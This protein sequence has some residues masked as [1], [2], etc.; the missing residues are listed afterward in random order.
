[1]SRRTVRLAGG[2]ALAL[3]VA[4][5]APQ[6]QAVVIGASPNATLSA[7]PVVVSFGAAASYAFTAATTPSGPGAAVATSGTAQVT[8]LGGVTDF[9]PGSSIDQTGEI[10]TFAAFPAASSIPYSAADD[11]IGLA[12]TLP[13]G[14]HYGYAE[15]SGPS[16]VS[17]GYE[18][19]PGVSILT[20][21]APASTAMP[22]PASMAL[23]L[24]GMTGALI[25]RRRKALGQ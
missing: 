10:Y 24:T 16:L 2:G 13:D 20:G 25:S 6:A 12:F 14:L 11:F 9:Y 4:L 5:V 22:E 8:S 3:A 7:T 1:M 15:V 17:Y 23:L 19:A 18:S 21:A